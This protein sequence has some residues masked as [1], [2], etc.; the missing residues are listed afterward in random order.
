VII[1]ASSKIERH[2][3]ERLSIMDRFLGGRFGPCR[4]SYI[5]AVPI[6]GSEVE[7]P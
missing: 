7:Q 4:T 1:V 6:V 5:I 3:A 2:A